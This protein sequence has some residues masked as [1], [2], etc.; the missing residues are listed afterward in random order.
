M[1]LE[2]QLFISQFSTFSSLIFCKKNQNLFQYNFSGFF[3]DIPEFIEEF[4]SEIPNYIEELGEIP[5]HM[6]V[7]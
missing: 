3:D 5:K 1:T 7:I 4:A 6:K 2:I